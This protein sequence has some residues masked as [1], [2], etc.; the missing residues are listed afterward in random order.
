MSLD[1]IGINYYKDYESNSIQYE[2]LYHFNYLIALIVG[3]FDSLA[4]LTNNKLNITNDT[5][6]S[7]LMSIC[8]CNYKNIIKSIG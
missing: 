5:I 7:L 3:I 8:L 1:Q 2:I 4:L 6:S